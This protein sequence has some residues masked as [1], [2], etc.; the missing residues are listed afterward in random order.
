M[1]QHIL[2]PLV[3]LL[4]PFLCKLIP[5]RPLTSRKCLVLYS[6][7]FLILYSV[8][9]INI[10]NIIPN[11]GPLA[12]DRAMNDI[13]IVMGEPELE[14]DL[15]DEQEDIVDEG[16]PADDVMVVDI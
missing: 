9:F 8:I 5:W 1:L 6:A 13:N 2:I 7:S 4:P 3:H 14:D 11:H 12:I 15:M 10:I 16:E